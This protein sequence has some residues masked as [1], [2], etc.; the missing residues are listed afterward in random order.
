MD[1]I[2]LQ[3]HIR[4]KCLKNYIRYDLSVHAEIAAILRLPKN[5]NM[6]NVRLVV[7]R[8]GMKM[9]KPCSKCEPVLRWL[10]INK[11]YYSCDG[12]LVRMNF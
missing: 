6:R 5:T 3:L 1:I 12:E 4:L 2:N 11:V 8:K 9:S 7:V 10:G